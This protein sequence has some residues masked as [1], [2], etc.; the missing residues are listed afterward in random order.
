[1]KKMYELIDDSGVDYEFLRA[2]GRNSSWKGMVR[3][4]CRNSD[5]TITWQQPDQPD[6]GACTYT[7][8]E[9]CFREVTNN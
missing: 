6:D 9:A 7:A 8:D 1:M 4:G 3:V 5:G 2:F